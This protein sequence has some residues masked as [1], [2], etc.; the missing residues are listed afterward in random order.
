MIEFKIENNMAIF[1]IQ[2]SDRPTNVI[3]TEFVN[4]LEKIVQEHFTPEKNY[5]AYIF[6]STRKDF[7]VGADLEMIQKI[8]TLDECLA[9]TTRLHSLFRKIEKTA[10]P[11]IAALTGSALGGGFELALCCHKIFC[12]DNPK[13]RL[14]LPE[15]T[16]GLLPGGGGTQ[17]LS[18]K[19]GYEAAIPL[20]IQGTLLEPKKALE[21]G[22][23]HEI[24]SNQEELFSKIQNFVAQNPTQ[25]Q[26]WDN[27]KFKLP[28]API[29]SP[30]GYQFFP[31]TA[32]TII[33]KTWGNYQAP[34]NI[35]KCVYEGLQLP[36]DQAIK[37]EE[38]YF[39][40]LVLS[41]KTKQMIKTLFFAMNECKK[42]RKNSL[43]DFHKI[44]KIGIIGAGMM[45][46]GI[47]Y[48]SAKAGLQVVLKDVNIDSANKGK[49]FSEK[50]LTKEV[51]KLR[52]TEMKK[53]EI[54]NRIQTTDK[55]QDFA[56]CDL[57]IEAV[58]EDR[59]VKE[60]VIRDTEN[61]LKKEC[62]LASNTSTLPITGLSK[63]SNRPQ[64]FIGLHFFSP[65]EK[66]QLVEVIVTPETNPETISASLDYVIK[67]GKTPIIVN[68]SRGF[69]TTR[70]FMSYVF[71]ALYA[72]L[73]GVPPALIENA[74]KACGM[75]VGPL[76]VADEVSL[77]LLHFVLKQA[78]QDAATDFVDETIFDFVN[79][80]VVEQNRLGRK[81]AK[82]FYEYPESG[83]KHLWPGLNQF[84]ILKSDLS[85]E[86]IKLRFLTRQSIEALRCLNEGV[87]QSSFEADVGALLGWGFPSYTGGPLSY[88]EYREKAQF[89]ADAEKFKQKY[90]RRFEIS[91]S[92][93]ASVP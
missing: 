58:T 67:I 84:G 50:L 18:R 23:L 64:Q 49:L 76:T 30:K 37:I 85:L 38:K 24:A 91:E 46:S 28:G 83:K 20:M 34:Q 21:L 26:A 7:L 2:V 55:T 52:L 63:Y 51:E 16:L 6:T 19:I 65:V 73:E 79:K 1:D 53:N 93:L 77:E 47:A 9:L 43:K 71:E 68:D 10:K 33:D 32:A 89:L 42:P 41:K 25:E 39:A 81:N 61:S 69:Y 74:G 27:P 87:L 13:I 82:G 31:S 48:S 3:H 22:I 40:E 36:F 75:A 86:E 70:V 11:V 60:I 14:G 29:H 15:V 8:Q 59:N 56:N 54:L 78:K 92:L 5:T 62:Y 35:L 66:M 90:G 80:L 12:L 88:I 57:I 72:L 45:G 4:R 17:R 44:E